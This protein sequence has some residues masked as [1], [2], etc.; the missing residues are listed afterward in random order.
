[1]V[2]LLVFALL[3]W[4]SVALYNKQFTPVSMV[5]LYTDSVG[6]E[7][8]LGAEVM[9]RGVQVGE[10]RSISATGRG[11]RLGLAIQPD[12]VAHLPANVTA[13]MVPTTLFGERYVD[14]LIPATPTVARL[15]AGT[16]IRQDH[17]ADAVEVEKVLNNLLPLLQASEPDKLS[18]FLTAFA[19]GLQ[20][21]GKT[22]GQT[23]VQLSSLLHRYNPH[24]AALDADIKELSGVARTFNQAS[25]DLL[26]A[27]D[28]FTVSSQ[29]YASERASFA[30][31]YAAVTTA[32]N[33]L[34]AFLSANS[35]NIIQLSAD[36]TATLQILARYSPEFP[37]VLTDLKNFVPAADK[38]LGKGT[39]QPGLHVQAIIVPEYVDARYQY[40]K[41]SPI[42]GD[43]RG[44]HCYSIP[45]NGLNPPLNDGTTPL[46]GGPVTGGTGAGQASTRAKESGPKRW[47]LG[48]A[49]GVASTTAASTDQPRANGG[50][51]PQTTASP[52]RPP[53]A[54]A[55]QTATTTAL[56]GSP[57]EGELVKELAALSLGKAP[58]SVPP[59][60]SLLLAP[61]FRGE[62]VSL[63]TRS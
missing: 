28:Y 7:M 19:Q 50:H 40:P 62:R 29:T 8:H 2:F 5:T 49:A 12:M 52:P 61:L 9:A 33:D 15:T 47:H 43:D 58:A 63:V 39:N 17:A 1:V 42:Y 26:Q 31:L 37:C 34:T 45:F 4:F 51:H 44:P 11:A 53:R 59:W 10:V 46:S 38:L 22:L 41:D 20:G 27:L 54:G 3:I 32:S 48:P 13:M 25:P 60:I 6:N 35:S 57:M 56:A 18:V 36:S 14:L 55:A 23:L 21:H 30:A 24:L 16:V